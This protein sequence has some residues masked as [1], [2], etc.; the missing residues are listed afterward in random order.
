VSRGAKP[1][2]MIGRHQN[3]FTAAMARNLDRLAPS[4]VLELTELALELRGGG[5]RHSDGIL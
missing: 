5:L 2:V 3:E 4:Q 1:V